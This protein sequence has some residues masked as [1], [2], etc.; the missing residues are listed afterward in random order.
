MGESFMQA[1][2][3]KNILTIGLKKPKT[4]PHNLP[5]HFLTAQDRREAILVLRR[6]AIQGIVVQWNRFDQ[7]EEE[8][9]RKIKLVH[10]SIPVVVLL[11]EPNDGLEIQVRSLGVTAV[12][13]G[14]I[15]SP[16][17]Q[18]ILEQVLRLRSFHHTEM[19]LSHMN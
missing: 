7:M 10:P 12:L 4:V 3:Q 19:T 13:P 15:D 5:I 17:L 14:D 9:I 16:A 8:F 6:N 2:S 18:P 1:L 11:D